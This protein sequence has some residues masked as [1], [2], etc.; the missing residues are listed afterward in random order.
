M[1]NIKLKLSPEEELLLNLCRLSFNDE[2]KSK[3]AGLVTKISDWNHFIWLANEHGIIAIT[4]H[5]LEQLNLVSHIPYNAQAT[6]KNLYLKSLA[7]NSFL[8]EKF[9]ELKKSLAEIGITPV[10]LKGMALE[11]GVYGNIGL[12]QMTDIDIFVQDKNA[13]LRA[14]KYLKNS[15]YTS[16]LLKSPLYSKILQDF[17]KHMPDL[18]KDGISLDMHFSLFDNDHH[19]ETL[20]I[21]TEKLELTI[22]EYHIHFLFLAKHLCDHE[23]RGESQLR[24]YIDLFQIIMSARVDIISNHVIE[25]AD[26]LGLKTIL[27]EKLF[28]LHKIWSVPLKEDLLN[29]LT[30]NQKSN[31]VNIFLGFLHDPKGQ[32]G[33]NKGARYRQTIRNIPTLRKKFIFLLGDIFPS[34]SF[35]QSR[36]NTKTRIWACFY[37]PIRVGKLLF[38]FIR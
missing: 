32:T 13:C 6:L 15:A 30:D 20:S 22:P 16:K 3:I 28:L 5:N 12:R 35:M 2:N 19:I 14:W 27:F 25:L 29:Q 34:V 10:V 23:L 18:Y 17:G 36:Y 11:P 24:L 26:K 31:A 4:F 33:I 7:R 1:N 8:V 38:L 37:Y 21:L 9:I